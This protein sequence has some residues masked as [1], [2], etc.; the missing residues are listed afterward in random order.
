MK[1]E[2]HKI[3]PIQEENKV[4]NAAEF[5][6]FPNINGNKRC[7]CSGM[8]KVCYDLWIDFILCGSCNMITPS[9]KR[10]MVQL[11]EHALNRVETKCSILR[12]I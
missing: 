11:A 7:L 3:I 5:Y 10:Q 12:T 1:Y 4:F 9:R 8:L 6:F 2:S